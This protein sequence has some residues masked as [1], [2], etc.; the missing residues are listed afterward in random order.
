MSPVEEARQAGRE[1]CEA[2]IDFKDI[3]AKYT[4]YTSYRKAWEQGYQAQAEE[5]GA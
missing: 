4:K 2:G 3:P 1:A 5:M